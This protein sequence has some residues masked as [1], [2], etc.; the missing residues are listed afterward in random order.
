MTRLGS[1]SAPLVLQDSCFSLLRPQL[2]GIIESQS[3]GRSGWYLVAAFM[4]VNGGL[5]HV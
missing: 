2:G 1:F 4:C 5:V 3:C